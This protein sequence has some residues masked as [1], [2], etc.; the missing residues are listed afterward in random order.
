VSSRTAYKE[1]PCLEK[2]TNK[3]Q[4]K[5]KT[6]TTTKRFYMYVCDLLGR[7]A[8]LSYS[9]MNNTEPYSFTQIY[10]GCFTLRRYQI[11]GL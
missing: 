1:K 5:T 10:S 7:Q 11:R 4:Q 6:T 2:Q 8:S 9:E 3:K